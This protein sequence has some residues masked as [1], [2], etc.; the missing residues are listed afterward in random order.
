M[1]RDKLQRLLT[2]ARNAVRD[3]DHQKL[4]KI[5]TTVT[6]GVSDLAGSSDA[7]I[8]RGDDRKDKIVQ[9]RLGNKN[10]AV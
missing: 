6:N 8:K 3:G 5:I 7:F 9:L 2:T 1:K 10:S 4:Y